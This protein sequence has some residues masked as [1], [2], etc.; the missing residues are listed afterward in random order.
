ML[1]KFDDFALDQQEAGQLAK[2]TSNFMQEFDVEVSPKVTAATGL[3][4]TA[5]MIY[6]P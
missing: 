6:G 1:I 4:T 2:A 5:A 3:V